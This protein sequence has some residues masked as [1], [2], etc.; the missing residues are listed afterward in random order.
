[1]HVSHIA[2]VLISL[3]VAG[4]LFAFWRGGPSERQA[5]G[6]ILANLVILRGLAIALSGTAY[7]IAELVVDAL[8]A[9]AL[10]VIVLRH[11]SLWLGAVMLLYAVQFS[12]HAFYF[13]TARPPDNLHAIINNVDF[14]GVV[15]CLVIGTAIAWW[16]RARATRAAAAP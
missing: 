15:D 2:T 5:A 12:S 1:M 3:V 8:T 10:L 6:V 13:V 14:I 4:C 9:L 11:G 16:R 7:G